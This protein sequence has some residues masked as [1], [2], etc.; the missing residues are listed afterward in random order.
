M[1]LRRMDPLEVAFVVDVR[2]AGDTFAAVNYAADRRTG[3]GWWLRYLFRDEN[4]I[5]SFSDS[6]IL[7]SRS[8]FNNLR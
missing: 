6:L 7:P 3:S 2:F 5:I 8:L 4:H 1:G